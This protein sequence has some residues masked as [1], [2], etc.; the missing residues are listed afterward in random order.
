M[1]LLP[2]SEGGCRADNRNLIKEYSDKWQYVGDRVLFDQLQG[3]KNVS[4]PL[5]G[6]LANT[7]IPYDIERKDSEY[8][9]LAEQVQ[10]ALTALSEATKDSE[11][12]FFC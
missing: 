12:G 8:P 6:L 4:L 10:V 7:D 1:P 2:T 3:G 11:Q 9:S 5:L